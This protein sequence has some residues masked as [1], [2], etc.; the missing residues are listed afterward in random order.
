VPLT[1]N[2]GLRKWKFVFEDLRGWGIQS[3]PPEEALE[4]LERG[5]ALLLDVRE[6]EKFQQVTNITFDGKFVPIN[7]R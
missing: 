4:L 7:I 2:S 5:G 6:L 3:I 1:L